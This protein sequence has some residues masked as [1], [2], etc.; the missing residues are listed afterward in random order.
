MADVAQIAALIGSAEA[1]AYR[2]EQLQIGRVVERAVCSV[3]LVDRADP[4]QI[5]GFGAFDVG[6]DFE[7]FC[8]DNDMDEKITSRTSLQLITM[9]LNRR[10]PTGELIQTL[11]NALFD[12]V[13]SLYNI[14]TT[15]S[16]ERL[17]SVYNQTKSSEKIGVIT[18][19]SFIPEL[20][21][22]DAQV[23]DNDDIAAVYGEESEQL[24][25]YYGGFFFAELVEAADERNKVLVADRYGHACGCLAVTSNIGF[26][27]LRATHHVGHF[28]GL[29]P[30]NALAIQLLTISSRQESRAIDLIRGALAQFPGATWLLVT[31]PR[32]V[33]FL[34]VLSHFT[35]VTPKTSQTENE[36]YVLHRATLT[37][38]MKTRESRLEDVAELTRLD[39]SVG[40]HVETAIEEGCD[41]DGVELKAFTF[42]LAETIIG[43][44]VIREESEINMVRTYFNIEQFIN[45]NQQSTN[46]HWRIISCAISPGY[47]ALTRH[48]LTETLRLV[49]G[50]TLYQ[51]IIDDKEPVSAVTREMLNIKPRQ[52]SHYNAEAL[53]ENMPSSE[54]FGNVDFG[55]LMYARKHAFEHRTQLNHAI[56]I[57]GSSSVGLACAQALAMTPHLTPNNLTLVADL[58]YD[59]ASKMDSVE[60]P[61]INAHLNY[62]R[63]LCVS[64][65]RCRAQMV[66]IRRQTKQVVLSNGKLLPYDVLLLATGAQHNGLDGKEP[67]LNGA[68]LAGLIK[69]LQDNEEERVFIKGT[70]MMALATIER[71]IQRGIDAGRIIYGMDERISTLFDFGKDD[72][73]THKLIK[74]CDID[75]GKGILDSLKDQGVDVIESVEMTEVNRHPDGAI[76]YVMVDDTHEYECDVFCDLSKTRKVSSNVFKTLSDA[77][78]VYDGALVV[79]PDFAT[80]NPFILAAGP[81]TKY[82]RRLHADTWRHDQFSATDI[83]EAVAEEILTRVGQGTKLSDQHQ[84]PL[85][86]GPL[87]EA[88][89][90]PGGGY[91][92]SIK[93]PPRDALSDGTKAKQARWLFSLKDDTIAKIHINPFGMIDQ[94]M[95]LSKSTPL[96]INNLV[97]IYGLHEKFVNSLVARYDE[98]LVPCLLEHISTPACQAV[99]HDRFKLLVAEL[100]E[101]IALGVDDIKP[102]V[103]TQLEEQYTKTIDAKLLEFLEH[104]RPL[105][106]MYAE[107][108]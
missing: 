15:N 20:F 88:S 17:I 2:A 49:N 43:A 18:R 90:L 31:L 10:C 50:S 69:R 104:N 9:V 34:P 53:G 91:F 8:A 6:D 11:F 14:I 21:V 22:R 66:G 28:S 1:K 99:T 106:T 73:L 54:C 72:L 74:E 83:G 89:Q 77:C 26:D 101:L 64:L 55:L 80:S 75:I 47:Q 39:F 56:V 48:A 60:S 7:Q 19:D 23:E 33:P 94:M 58:F 61:L 37:N 107:A 3:T 95:F 13:P 5:V 52:A 29:T 67:G 65:N 79:E 71:L 57:V 84:V 97:R 41:S 25:A 62:N 70:T 68:Q 40:D 36:V 85:F 92:L 24:K 96:P 32:Q 63:G 81:M 30:Q 12:A 98:E 76:D 45:F 93:P 100:D 108:T 38:S 102:G 82:P 35:R 105:L 51:R 4:T 87:V 42:T 16:D 44:C 78:L 27:R 86:T 103:Q 59:D 46:D